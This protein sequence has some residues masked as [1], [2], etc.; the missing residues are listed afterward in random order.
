[1]YLLVTDKRNLLDSIDQASEMD[2]GQR[3]HVK[4]NTLRM[5][6]QLTKRGEKHDYKFSG[7]ELPERSQL[8]YVS[9]LS[10]L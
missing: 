7:M 8:L 5:E 2:Y 4:G 3:I 1:M 9:E 6:K 10:I